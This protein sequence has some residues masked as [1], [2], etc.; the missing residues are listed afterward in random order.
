MSI[1]H[2]QKGSQ[3]RFR[4]YREHKYLVFC[5]NNL[6][7]HLA[8][9]DFHDRN[10]VQDLKQALQE[11]RDLLQ[12]HADNEELRIHSLLASKGSTLHQSTET[13]HQ[14]HHAFFERIS[15]NL[16]QLETLSDPVEIDAAG[17]EITLDFRL[18]YS[19]QL[20]H[21]DYEERV[22]LPELQ[23]LYSDDVLKNI[24]RI[25]YDLMTP[26]QMLHMVTVLFPHMNYHDKLSYL[27][28][29]H[30]AESEKFALIWDSLNTLL[31]ETETRQIKAT[32]GI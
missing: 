30:A 21:L 3:S 26:D 11:L 22:L 18:F 7:Q 1:A 14:E 20:R 6:L 24:H 4:I 19:E 23:R 29:L 2:S 31:T 16:Q 5:F 15:Q 27:S 13:D 28:E 32:L 8:Q 17:Y 25:S 9:S 12:G 10:T